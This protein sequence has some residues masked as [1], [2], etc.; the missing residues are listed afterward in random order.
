MAK[1]GRSGE[2]N[3][4]EASYARLRQAHDAAAARHAEDRDR[5]AAKRHAADA[6]LKLE[7]KWG[8]RVDALKRLS[9]VSR[10]IDRLRREQDAALLERDE[11]I[12]QLREVGETWNSLA[13]Q[14][15]LSRQALSK[16]TL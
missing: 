1:R 9:E 11:L 7:A 10:S 4:R 8:T 6:M 13:A 3:R 16:R 5:E 2:A 15:R 12:A 14:T